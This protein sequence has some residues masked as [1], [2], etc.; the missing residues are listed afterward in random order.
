MKRARNIAET[1]FVDGRS[2][3]A[4]RIEPRQTNLPNIV[5]LHEGLGSVAHWKDFAAELAEHTGAGVFAY[6]R[7]GHGGSDALQ[8]P[9]SVSYMHHEAQ[10]VLPG[11]LEQAQI[12]QPLLLGHSDGA[13]IAIIYAGTYPQSPAGLIL[14]SPHV[15]IED[16]SV[17]SIREHAGPTEILDLDQRALPRCNARRRVALLAIHTGML[18]LKRVACLFVIEDS[19]VPFDNREVL[20]GARE[21]TG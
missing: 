4:V 17:A 19:R 11:I 3:E 16:I 14:E 2:I 13:S 21:R 15:F 12:E 18:A 1:Y 10:V 7:Y 5:M 20:V 8:E 6:S 9:R